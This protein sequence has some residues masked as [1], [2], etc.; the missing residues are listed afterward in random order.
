MSQ[1]KLS[2][3]LLGMDK[4]S[5]SIGYLNKAAAAG[6]KLGVDGAAGLFEDEAKAIVP[7]KTGNLRDHIHF[8]TTLDDAEHQQRAVLPVYEL[9]GSVA[10]DP[11][12]A[13]RIEFGFFD[14]DSLG[15][16]Y[17]QAAQPYMAPAF[18]NQKDPAAT[19]IKAEVVGALD[20]QMNAIA[21]GRH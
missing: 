3:Q 18:E 2:V 20:E 7:V 5:L 12:Y 8:Y 19:L 4:L 16:Q 6:L 10:L 21:A 9:E 17:H 11:P 15:R 1:N 13:R 14:K